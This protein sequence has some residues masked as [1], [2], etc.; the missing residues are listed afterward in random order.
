MI[1]VAVVDDH[2]MVRKGIISY[3]ATEAGIKVIGE[4]ESGNEAV[5]LVLNERPEIVLMDLL[6]E[7]GNGIEA[8]RE[9]LKSYPG[10]KIIIITSY[11]DDEQVFPAIEAGAFSYMLKTANAAEVVNAIKKAAQGESV[12]ESKVAGKMV[13]RFREKEKKP[14]DDLTE[15]EFDVLLCI[16][17]GM[18]NQEI[19]EELFIGI[20]TVKTHVSNILSKL[21]VTDRTQAAVYANRNGIIKRQA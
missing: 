7:N 14:H 5:K 13:S 1:S 12:I 11:Y 9:I 19:S 2:E 16:G 8:T 4:A 18:T 15:R 21:G 6:M 17:E 3:L 20:K 10:C